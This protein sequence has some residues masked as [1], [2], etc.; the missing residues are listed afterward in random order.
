MSL[1]GEQYVLCAT[2]ESP[3]GIFCARR[4]PRAHPLHPRLSGLGAN[5]GKGAEGAARRALH[6]GRDQQSRCRQVRRAGGRA[7]LW[8][9]HLR[10]RCA[11]TCAQARMDALHAG[12]PFARRRHRGAVRTRSSRGSER[13]RAARS[14][15]PQRT[16]LRRRRRRTDEDRR[17]VDDDAQRAASARRW[18]RRHSRSRRDGRMAEPACAGHARRARTAFARLVGIDVFGQ[19]RCAAE[20]ATHAGASRRW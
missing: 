8:R 6:D 7:R 9:A 13:P 17:R 12:R 18:R 20:N 11:R 16:H 2:L 14:G 1:H 19:A 3:S 15:E 4:R 10:G 5:L